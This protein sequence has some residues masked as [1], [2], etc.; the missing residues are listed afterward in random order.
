MERPQLLQQKPEY[1]F[2]QQNKGDS[3]NTQTSFPQP[4]VACEFMSD[5]PV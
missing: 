2:A 3:E 4:S 1:D 5:Q